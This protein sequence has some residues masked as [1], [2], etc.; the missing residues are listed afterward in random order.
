MQWAPLIKMKSL[1]IA[2]AE[3]G[4]RAYFLAGASRYRGRGGPYDRSLSE[5]AQQGDW[6]MTQLASG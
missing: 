3:C 4:N 2:A 1:P 5:W 6:P